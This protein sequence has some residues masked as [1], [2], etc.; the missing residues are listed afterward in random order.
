M[1]RLQRKLRRPG[2]VQRELMKA[3]SI[4]G[5]WEAMKAASETLAGMEKRAASAGELLQ[6]AALLARQHLGG[7]EEV[8]RLLEASLER[9]P[10]DYFSLQLLLEYALPQSEWDLA[11]SALSRMAALAGGSRAA[12]FHYQRGRIL[13]E[14]LDRSEDGLEAFRSAHEADRNHVST[15][16]ALQSLYAAA[17][18]HEALCSLFEDEGE[19]LG[20]GDGQV[21]F[22][23]A[24]RIAR[25]QLGDAKRAVDLFNRALA[26]KESSEIRHEL[27]VVLGKAE[28]FDGLAAELAK[29]AELAS[30]A[31]KDWARF[32]LARAKEASGDLDEALALYTEVSKNPAAAPASDAVARILHAQKNFDGLL[33]FWG[34]QAESQSDSNIK[35]ALAFRMG[36][37]CEGHLNDQEKAQGYFE[38]ILD[39]APGYLPALEALERVYTRLE[40]WK[41]LAAIYEQR[42][43]LC[44]APA[45]IALQIHRAAAVY[46]FRLSDH[47]RAKEFYER[48]LAQV[49]DFPP[50]L[51]AYLRLLEGEGAWKQMSAALSEAAKATE[52]T[53]EKVS[54]YYRSARI[55][56]D[57]VGDE[58]EALVSLRHCTELSPGF[59]PAHTLLKELVA[60]SGGTGEHLEMQISEARSIDQLE[61]RHWLLLEAAVLSEES[62]NGDPTALVNEIL[63]DEPTHAGALQYRESAALAA[64]DRSAVVALYSEAIQA[65]E[66]DADRV[67]LATVLMGH[68]WL[69]ET[70][71]VPS[72]RPPRSSMRKHPSVPWSTSHVCWRRTGGPRMRLER[73]RGLGRIRSRPVCRSSTWR[74]P[75]KRW[76]PWRKPLRRIPT[77]SVCS[78]R[79]CSSVS[80]SE[81]K[82]GWP[83]SILS[84][85][86]SP[87]P[88]RLRWSTE[89]LLDTSCRPMTEGKKRLRP[90]RSPSMRVPRRAK[91]LRL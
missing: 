89:H 28:D 65:F 91:P 1:Q 72:S 79:P 9:N 62:G 34:A 22:A 21:Y 46:E 16:L 76:P 27:Q 50:S 57:K 64:G 63:A 78:S 11:E 48:A 74:R 19:R 12:A 45:A 37:I 6:D 18:N 13:L 7:G 60:R 40:D 39:H 32:R 8:R 58:P 3:Q 20:G 75:K 81:T 5:Q 23:E 24:A 14:H 52:D 43:I 83:D 47:K 30:D 55:L 70:C 88:P 15:T 26:Q 59:L 2:A 4:S 17:G 71:Q 53:N 82:N 31:Q 42:A 36:E 56:A 85:R 77:M 29:E 38:S 90:T 66:E 35:V 84:S 67:R 41:K 87:N 86:R 25:D 51:D 44:D 33:D 68:H 61:K 73:W 54:F 80:E 10:E 49:A 69:P